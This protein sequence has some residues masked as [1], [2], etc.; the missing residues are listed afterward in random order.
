LGTVAAVG[1]PESSPWQN[2]FVESFYGRFRED[3]LNR[4]HLHTLTEVLVVNQDY[5]Q[6]YNQHRPHIRLGHPSKA[7]FAN[8]CPLSIGD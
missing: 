4:E 6:V 3:C 5:R 8:K 7:A 1:D 2:G